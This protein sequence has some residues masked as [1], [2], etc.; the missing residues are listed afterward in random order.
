VQ[1]GA[2]EVEVELLIDEIEHTME[3]EVHRAGSVLSLRGGK[4][5]AELIGMLE[6]LLATKS[7]EFNAA[8][9]AALANV[10]ASF[11]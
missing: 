7:D 6:G 3:H 2:N 4:L 9:A 11:A 5:T 10:N 8:L 1:K